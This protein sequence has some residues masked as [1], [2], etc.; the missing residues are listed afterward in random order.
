[1]RKRGV[2]FYILLAY[3]LSQGQISLNVLS[4]TIHYINYSQLNISRHTE[5]AY[6]FI[7]PSTV[8]TATLSTFLNEI[9]LKPVSAKTFTQDNKAE[10]F[11]EIRTNKSIR[12]HLSVRLPNIA[13]RSTTH[14]SAFMN[15]ILVTRFQINR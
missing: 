11:L 10:I 5:T 4:E 15:H 2:I 14:H 3:P 8:L 6:V 7:Y 1:M 12:L 9:C 13:I